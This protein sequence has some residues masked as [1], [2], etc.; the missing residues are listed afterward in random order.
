MTKSQI[1]NVIEFRFPDYLVY[2]V[3]IEEN[4]RRGD[5]VAMYARRF[6]DPISDVRD[7]YDEQ[8]RGKIRYFVR[9]AN[10]RKNADIL[11]IVGR[12]NAEH[13]PVLDRRFRGDMSGMS[14]RPCWQIIDGDQRSVVPCLTRET[15]LLSE[16]GFPGMEFIHHT[17]DNDLYPWS[18]DLLKRGPLNFDPDAFEAEMRAKLRE[19]QTPSI[20]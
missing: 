17:Y 5:S 18:A 9:L 3:R 15:A 11:R 8:V 12:M 4:S 19:Q 6:R 20:H 2:G 10:A 1:G 14:E 7:L 16:D 13:L